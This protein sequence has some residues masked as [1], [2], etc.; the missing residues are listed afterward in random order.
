MVICLTGATVRP[1]MEEREARLAGPVDQSLRGAAGFVSAKRYTADDGE[2]I[3]IIRFETDDD[4][5]RWR[6]EGLHGEIKG[7]AEDVYESFWVQ[8]A[9]V[10]RD[11]VWAPGVDVSGHQT[12]RSAGA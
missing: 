3:T 5:V 12:G 1:G 7:H 6:D 11:Y 2:V 9:S 10:H 8:T 4:L